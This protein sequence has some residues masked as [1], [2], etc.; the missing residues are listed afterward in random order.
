[1]GS[2]LRMSPTIP[3]SVCSLWLFLIKLNVN[4]VNIIDLI[5]ERKATSTFYAVG[6]VVRPRS[7]HHQS[8]FDS[9]E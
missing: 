9:M 3:W 5:W 2:L 7:V 6:I 4:K 8:D 1:M